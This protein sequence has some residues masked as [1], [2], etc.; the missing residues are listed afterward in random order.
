MSADIL[1]STLVGDLPFTVFRSDRLNSAHGG[2]CIITRDCSVKAV[3]VPINHQFTRL[4]I[5]AIDILNVLNPI[6]IITIYRSPSR[7]LQSDDLI[8]ESVPLGDMKV[9]IECLQRLCD[10]NRTVIITGDL[11]LPDVNWDAPNLLSDYDDCS[12]MF[13]AFA[14][15]HGFEQFVREITRPSV[16]TSGSGS[17]IDLVLGND[18]HVIH[19]LNVTVPFSTS[20]HYSIAFETSYLPLKGASTHNFPIDIN[21]HNFQKCDWDQIRNWMANVDWSSVFST[22]I[23]VREHA[24]VFYY[25]LNDC[26]DRFVPMSCTRRDTYFHGIRY[27]SHIRKLQAK[28]RS[29][30]RLYKRFRSPV[31]HTRYKHLS[32][33]CRRAIFQFIEKREESLISSGN[34]GKF[35][36][37]ANSKLNSK[38][39]VGPL[40]QADG[41]LTVDPQVKANML[42]DYFGSVFV[43]DDG[44]HPIP[45]SRVFGVKLT[46]I[47]FTQPAVNKVLCRLKVNSVGGPDGIPPIFLKQVSHQLSFTLA[48]LYQLFFDTTFIPPVWL[49]A[50]ITPIFK[51]GDASL[52]SN[53]RPISLTCNLCKIMETIVKDQI[54]SYLS[55]HGLLSKEQHAFIGK[56]STVTNLLECVHDWALSLHNRIP[57]DV[58]YIDFSHAFDC[59]V[60]S[61]L[62]T[63]LQSFGIDGML[64]S[65]I[66]AFLSNRT[67]CVLVE[68]ISSSWINVI[69]GVPQGSVLG[70]VFFL[71]YVD[72]ITLIYPGLVQYKL[73]A[74]DLKIYS[75]VDSSCT[76]L[77]LHTVLRELENWCY[78]WQL[79]VN[80][81]KTSVVHLGF[82]NP[83]LS[84][85]FS[86]SVIKCVES[87]RD[88]GVEIDCGLTF[89]V[90][91][92]NVVSKAYAR[93]A[94]LFRGFSTRNLTLLRR[95]YVTYVRPILEYASNVWNPHLLKN[96]N[97]LE[98]VQRYFTKR[99]TVLR[100]LPYDER[101]ALLDLDT[102]E[103]RRLKADLTLY[104]KIVHGLTPWPIDRYFSM[105]VHSRQT[106]LTE[107]RNNFSISVP[108]CRTVAYQNDFFHRCVSCWNNLPTAVVNATSLSRFKNALTQI[109]LSD[110]LRYSF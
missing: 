58:I 64:L 87:V 101:L 38:T 45:V 35:Y 15:Q 19:N 108:L 12:S 40:R 98:R 85:R 86:D 11:N 22:C 93:I 88:L 81:S 52:P 66:C 104:Y 29:S 44:S 6:R 10:V 102:L 54:I 18:S 80:I 61:K 73:F 43:V 103:S 16:S 28:K 69:S 26:I 109:D 63:K 13:V 9:L 50:N 48:Y 42:S 25:I 60:H 100:N 21:Y 4:E 32:S 75:N 20:D 67:Q 83:H 95:A 30:W 56:H 34:L 7:R 2:A 74:D 91:V 82:N 49:T 37:Y 46:S 68:G 3:Q 23:N 33:Q 78:M 97:A 96:I 71:L 65:W 77:N 47:I 39:N 62:C 41:S 5:V 1:S 14:K 99:I 110:Y 107:C 72:D 106:R 53:Y 76:S 27:P 84:Y 55:T 57:Q 36:R 94:T 70:P 105:S 59:V 51:K 31:F 79:Q 8:N 92:N 24:D 90:H 89:D 17:L